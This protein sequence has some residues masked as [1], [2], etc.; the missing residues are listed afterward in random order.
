[1]PIVAVDDDMLSTENT[2]K[3]K[4]STETGY[5]ISIVIN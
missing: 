4:M 5:D 1:M 3:N 2:S